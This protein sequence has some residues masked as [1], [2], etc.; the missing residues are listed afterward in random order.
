MKKESYKDLKEYLSK[1]VLPI[2][3][4]LAENENFLSNI[5]PELKVKVLD[6]IEDKYKEQKEYYIQKL[7]NERKKIILDAVGSVAL[8]NSIIEEDDEYKD[9][10]YVAL[11]SSDSENIFYF[12]VETGELMSIYNKKE[13]QE[14]IKNNFI[15]YPE[16]YIDTTKSERECSIVEKYREEADNIRYQYFS[17]LIRSNLEDTK[18][19][20]L[21]KYK[22]DR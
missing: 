15:I 5:D 11:N 21:N 22:K 3:W 17:E 10:I 8:G 12:N 14:F 2:D 4:M 18:E 6:V 9:G 13:E 19:K 16:N 1:K 7:E 20:I